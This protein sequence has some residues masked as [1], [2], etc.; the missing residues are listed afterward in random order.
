MFS[1]AVGASKEFQLNVID[2]GKSGSVYPKIKREWGELFSDYVGRIFREGLGKKKMDSFGELKS[3]LNHYG[4]FFEAC[5]P[6][7]VKEIVASVK[8]EIESGNSGEGGF[9][10]RL[11]K[12]MP[13]P[14]SCLPLLCTVNGGKTNK[15]LKEFA[16]ELELKEAEI[17][18]LC[19][20]DGE[21]VAIRAVCS[22]N[23]ALTCGPLST[24][25]Y[26]LFYSPNADFTEEQLKQLGKELNE[27]KM[28]FD[29][30]ETE[31]DR[32]ELRYPKRSGISEKYPFGADPLEGERNAFK[33]ELG[34]TDEEIDFLIKQCRCN[35]EIKISAALSGS[36]FDEKGSPLTCLYTISSAEYPLSFGGPLTESFPRYEVKRLSDGSIRVCRFE[37]Q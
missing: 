20:R 30:L 12:L 29:Q 10:P 35:P 8:E 31:L 36:Y 14:L 15:G 1:T 18:T 13:G 9:Y 22:A 25:E 3:F 28:T 24:Y 4:I 6:E 34:F 17:I 27:K 23:L 7:I 33:E 21:R 26:K 2:E 5:D 11:S 37:L 16:E 19:N 32:I